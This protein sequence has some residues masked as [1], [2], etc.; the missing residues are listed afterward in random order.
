MPESAVQLRVPTPDEALEQSGVWIT[1]TARRIHVRMPW[2][3][4]DDMVQSGIVVTL[5]LREKYEPDR[6]VAFPIY[7]KPRV[8]GTMV[9]MSRQEGAIRRGENAYIEELDTVDENSAIDVLI[10][11][12]DINLISQA[13]EALPKEERMV[14]SLFY[15][16]EVSNKDISAIMGVSEVRATR[17][18]KRALS[19]LA[20]I[21]AKNLTMMKKNPPKGLA[22][23]SSGGHC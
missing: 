18:R 11:I 15:F 20:E 8:F 2:T 21:V 4:V 13:I 3:E 23:T 12:E 9:D 14:I 17:Y 16:D 6:G 1:R 22:S 10:R 19:M 7:I 5:E